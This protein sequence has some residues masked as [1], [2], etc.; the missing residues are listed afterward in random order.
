MFTR[1]L[2]PLNAGAETT[3]AVRIARSL[4]RQMNAA[5]ITLPLPSRAFTEE[6]E[7]LLLAAALI[8][9]ADLIVLP[10]EPASDVRERQGARIP[11]TLLATSPVPVLL[12]PPMCPDAGR[13]EP[14]S[15]A[16][17]FVIAPLD[18]SKEAEQALPYAVALAE[19]CERVL[20][21]THVVPS[22]ALP[23]DDDE[24]VTERE[25]RTGLH[26]LRTVRLRLATQSG[27]AVESMQ[28]HGNVADA[29]TQLLRA[30]ESS[31]M[32]LTA[33]EG[34]SPD[35]R[36]GDGVTRELIRRGRFPLMFIPPAAIRHHAP[37]PVGSRDT[38]LVASRGRSR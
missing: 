12:A 26:Y 27:V 33:H 22:I 10:E 2:V 24:S 3:G 17:S 19:R 31:L 16:A 11:T 38:P 7:S 25:A 36:S 30:H 23:V 9:R 21:L 28:L 18:G 15:L 32:V 13:P 20:L 8:E 4:T 14:L 1:I 5:L 34:Q 35:N 6:K 37:M 29:L